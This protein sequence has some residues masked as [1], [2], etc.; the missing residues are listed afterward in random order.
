MEK[1]SKDKHY[2]LMY[3]FVA[4]IIGSGTTY[5][6][7]IERSNSLFPPLFIHLINAYIWTELVYLQTIFFGVF[8]IFTYSNSDF[9]KMKFNRILIKTMLCLTTVIGAFFLCG[10]LLHF[11]STNT[12]YD[13]ITYK[14]YKFGILLFTFIKLFMG[15]FTYVNYDRYVTS[16]C[17]NPIPGEENN[18]INAV[19]II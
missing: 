2:A 15:F 8:F 10:L 11:P 17:M 12:L 6:F 14:E 7:F 9:H 3:L 13:L 1:I 19:I 4:F 5:L 16:C 18:G